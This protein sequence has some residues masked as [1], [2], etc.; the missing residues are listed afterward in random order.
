IRNLPMIFEERPFPGWATTRDNYWFNDDVIN[1]IIPIILNHYKRTDILYVESWMYALVAAHQSENFVNFCDRYE[2]FNKDILMIT[3]NTQIEGGSHWMLGIIIIKSRE[4]ILLDSLNNKYRNEQFTV[5]RRMIFMAAASA[6]VKLD[7]STWR[8]IYAEDTVKQQNGY[9]CG[10]FV[11]LYAYSVIRNEK[12][13]SLPSRI[14]RRWINYIGSYFDHEPIRTHHARISA[15]TMIAIRDI[16]D[17][18]GSELNSGIY[19]E[20]SP[21]EN[22][23]LTF[24]EELQNESNTC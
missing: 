7:I 2:A 21:V 24:A 16:I 23:L 19:V 3:L 18:K 13:F 5:L 8:C 6:L 11:I 12:F 1:C 17:E 10:L 4:I 22:E 9:D 20:S 15:K 14:G